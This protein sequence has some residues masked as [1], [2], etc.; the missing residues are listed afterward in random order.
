MTVLYYDMTIGECLLL[1][2]SLKKLTENTF[3]SKGQVNKSHLIWVRI[4][5]VGPSKPHSCDTDG[6]EQRLHVGSIALSSYFFNNTTQH[7]IA[8]I[9]VCMFCT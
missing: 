5:L 6:L 9:G 7:F 2:S 8:Q 1:M 4:F 3:S